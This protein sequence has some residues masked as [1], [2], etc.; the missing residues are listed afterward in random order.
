MSRMEA[1]VKSSTVVQDIGWSPRGSVSVRANVHG[2]LGSPCGMRPCVAGGGLNAVCGVRL[3][4][5]FG[6]A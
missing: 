3:G 2:R 1:K 6:A 4:G 5:G